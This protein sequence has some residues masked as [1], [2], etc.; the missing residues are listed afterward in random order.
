MTSKIILLRVF[1][2][3]FLLLGLYKLCVFEPLDT[4]CWNPELLK[5]LADLETNSFDNNNVLPPASTTSSPITW[6]AGSVCLLLLVSIFVLFSKRSDGSEPTSEFLS[7]TI[8][9][10]W[11]DRVPIARA[12][13]NRYAPTYTG[14]DGTCSIDS[15][16][17]IDEQIN[18]V[19]SGKNYFDDTWENHWV[20]V[21][22]GVDCE[23][24]GESLANTSTSIL[25]D[26][27]VSIYAE[28]SSEIIVDRIL[29]ALTGG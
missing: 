5:P 12:P 26:S 21:K 27:S 10:K 29:N 1:P 13:I 3:I 7:D 8:D 16:S 11:V 4:T 6:V 14:S 9:S 2:V 19:I 25:N 23:S 24:L 22:P 15:E 17:V 28:P 18:R 20:S